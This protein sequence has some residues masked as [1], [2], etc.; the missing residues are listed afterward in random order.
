[1]KPKFDLAKGTRSFLLRVSLPVVI[2]GLLW[3]MM[4]WS[5]QSNGVSSVALADDGKDIRR[6]LVRAINKRDLNG[7]ETALTGLIKIGGKKN[8]TTLVKLLPRIPVEDD[9]IYWAIVEGTCSFADKEAME[10]I[11]STIIRYM[12]SPLSRDLLYGLSKNRSH[13]SMYAL[14]PILEKGHKDLKIMAVQKLAHIPSPKV[15]DALIE[16]LVDVERKVKEHQNDE[17]AREIG[18]ALNDITGQTFG[19]LSINWKGWWK[20][21]R[22]TTLGPRA[23]KG[24]DDDYS[25]GTVVGDLNRRRKEEYY[26][27]KKAPKKGVVVL[28]AKYTKKVQKNLNNDHIEDV[29]QQMDVPYTVVLRENFDKFDLSGTGTIV[30]NCAQF[31]NMCICPKCKPAGTTKNR[32]KTCTGCNVH[33]DFSA[34][35]SKA[36]IKKLQKFVKDGGYIFGEDWVV[37]EIMEK[38]FPKYVKA[39]KVLRTQNQSSVDVVPGRGMST[40]PYLRGMFESTSINF[41][42][43]EKEVDSEKKGKTSVKK[44]EDKKNPEGKLIK[45]KHRWSIDD[46]SWAFNILDTKNILIL[47]SS[48]ELSQRTD[49]QGAV[50]FAFSPGGKV[51]DIGKIRT[52]RPQPILVKESTKKGKTSVAKKKS[53]G[54]GSRGKYKSK[55]GVVMQ[56]LSHFGKQESQRDEHLLQ[57]LLLN[58]IID[59]NNERLIRN[60]PD[61]ESND[62]EDGE[63]SEDDEFEDDIDLDLDDT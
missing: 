42:E 28:S 29:L 46:E 54:T 47:L 6:L 58:F 52:R 41:D 5:T 62:D 35:L 18:F 57:N 7:V 48:G 23:K 33:I 3:G 45:L 10:Y 30:I 44:K 50:A 16:A 24:S 37:K 59:A 43:L 9:E 39:G 4:D 40:H 51:S 25:G 31:H 13:N 32:L 22:D 60:G 26:E 19:P 63:K 34:K 49:G 36:G 12:R 17:L 27:L 11:G 1:M 21:N 15:V 61:P 53:S 55:P 56:V 8:A 2:V 20:N 38:A 14:I